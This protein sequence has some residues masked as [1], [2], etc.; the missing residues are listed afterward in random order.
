MSKFLNSINE[1]EESKNE[2]FQKEK[3]VAI[4][5]DYTKL[6]IT[7]AVAVVAIIA[8][9]FFLNQ[10]VDVTNMIGWSLSD[11]NNWASSNELQLVVHEI[12]DEAEANTVISQNVLEG[13]RVAQKSSIEVELSLG[14]DPKAIITL[15]S[16]D[17][18]WTKTQVLTWLEENGIENFTFVNVEDETMLSG[19]VLSV[20][21]PESISDYLREQAIEFTVTILPAE[22]EIVVLDF[23]N[24]TVAQI[25]AWAS[26][27]EMSVRYTEGFSDTTASGKVLSQS[28][29]S[30][31]IM[32]PDEALTITLS[33]GPAIKIIDFTNVNATQAST[34]AKD[35][36]IDL[37]I[38]S[39][40]S[41]QTAKDVAIYQSIGKDQIVE[42]GTDLTMF[43]SLGN[44]ITVA[45][46][47]GQA[48]T[49]LQSF[50]DTQNQM[51]AYL[52]INVSYSYSA[53]VAVNKIISQSVRDA[54][55]GIGS[56]IDVI[57]SLGNL[58]TVPD[59][60][61]LSTSSAIDT[62]NAV[63]AQCTTSKLTCQILFTD[64]DS[65]IGAVLSQSQVAGVNIADTTVVE[66]RIA[67]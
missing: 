32:N 59:F 45:S 57:V 4:K 31:E 27:N 24:Y 67:D 55:V 30:G 6:Y 47:V 2:S 8:S 18:S 40:Y 54:K 1:A 22:V 49:T 34:W 15:P 7:A 10:K 58:V 38:V 53:S 3:F 33:K 20:S 41:S 36:L 43:Y 66:I 48:I 60:T 61:S 25:D 28:I 16:F 21:T 23:L 13:E 51:K 19:T 56:T 35:N 64:D 17:E 37:T 44:E 9:F 14:F 11:A 50:V 5:K 52:S 46:Y 65:Q 42:Q 63:S 29:V 39:E 26:E 62:Y 12:Y